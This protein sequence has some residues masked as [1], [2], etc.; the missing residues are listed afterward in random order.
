MDIGDVADRED[1]AEELEEK[2]GH[3]Y[4][5]GTKMNGIV[6]FIFKPAG[7]PLALISMPIY[8]ECDQTLAEAYEAQVASAST[9][10]GG[11]I[12]EIAGPGNDGGPAGQQCVTIP[13]RFAEVEVLDDD[14]NV[15]S[16]SFEYVPGRDVCFLG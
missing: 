11:W 7:K 14:G 13:G 5:V 10:G 1:V 6:R 2:F 4:P 9:G 3:E 15:V 8:K 12:G 16:T